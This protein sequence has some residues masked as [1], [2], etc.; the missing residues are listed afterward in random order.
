MKRTA[1]FLFLILCIFNPLS[2]QENLSLSPEG[3]RVYWFGFVPTGVDL[4]LTYTSS[5]LLPD[6]D[7]K[8]MFQLG[9]GYE[10]ATVWRNADG[11]VYTDPAPLNKEINY[12][13]PNGR[14]E[15]GIIQGLAWDRIRERNLLEGFLIYRMRYDRNIPNEFTI[16]DDSIFLDRE[17]LF[18]NSLFAGLV[19]NNLDIDKKHKTKNGFYAEASAEWGPSFLFN[20]LFGYS[21][22][23]RLNATLKGFLKIFDLDQYGEKNKLSIYLGNFFSA[24]FAL[25]EGIPLYVSQYFGGTKLRRGLG[26]SVRGFEKKAWDGTF[27]LVNNFEVRVNGPTLFLP[28]LV[29]GFL[30]YFDAGYTADYFA[31]ETAKPS[32]LAATGVG[33]YLNVFDFDYVAAYLQ[34]PLAGLRK[35]A[36]PY[37]I[38]V[39]LGLH[40]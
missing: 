21:D 3:I 2:A 39:E 26:G 6:L 31:D 24:D 18:G 11:S 9:G 16:I 20:D 32:F 25:G 38:A 1:G 7:T 12:M 8:L 5:P 37:A 13:Q 19:F 23:L 36:K 10:E 22:F 33:L 17:G 14:L 4:R 35:D 29:P 15:A 28:S 30:V 40:F 34:V 27:K